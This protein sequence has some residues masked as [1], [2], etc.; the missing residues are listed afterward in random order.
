MLR[1]K[2]KYSTLVVRY[3]HNTIYGCLRQ[4]RMS[5]QNAGSISLWAYTPYAF[6]PWYRT[7]KKPLGTLQSY[8]C[9]EPRY[10][11]GPPTHTWYA[12]ITRNPPYRSTG[13]FVHKERASRSMN[14]AKLLTGIVPL[15]WCTLPRY[16]DVSLTTRRLLWTMLNTMS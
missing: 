16:V 11:M 8:D 6:S 1:V 2:N 4:K 7:R 15:V 12:I 5:S 9:A 14:A 13:L 10:A 3:T